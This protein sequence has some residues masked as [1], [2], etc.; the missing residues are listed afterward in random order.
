MG[1]LTHQMPAFEEG[2]FEVDLFEKGRTAGGVPGEKARCCPTPGRQDYRTM[3]LSLGDYMRKAGFSKAL[4]GLSGGVD[5]A[6]V[7]TIACDA[8]G[9]RER[10]LRDAALANTPPT[11][12][13]DDAR[14]RAE[15]WAAARHRAHRHAREAVLEA[16]AELFEGT[17][18]GVTEEN[19][20]SRLRG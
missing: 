14:A 2:L 11:A 7:A 1:V 6:I 8:L 19:I 17:E 12:S 10:A 5:S 18:P 13:L 9:T 3:V 4:L 20:Q 16:L 15:R